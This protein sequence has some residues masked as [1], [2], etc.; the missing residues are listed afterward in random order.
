[1]RIFSNISVICVLK[2]A[3]CPGQEAFFYA[4]DNRTALI[5]KGIT[6]RAGTNQ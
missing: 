5:L 4:K 2:P 1:M 3:F 6:D